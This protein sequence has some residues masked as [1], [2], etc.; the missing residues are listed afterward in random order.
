MEIGLGLQTGNNGKHNYPTQGLST[1]QNAH[2]QE[3]SPLLQGVVFDYYSRLNFPYC[4]YRC[5]LCS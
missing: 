1:D 2:L 4:F 5:Y 3:L